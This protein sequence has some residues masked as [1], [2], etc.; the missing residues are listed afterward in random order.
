MLAKYHKHL[1]LICSF[2]KYGETST[3]SCRRTFL[4]CCAFCATNWCMREWQKISITSL[5]L[6]FDPC[7]Y[8]SSVSFLWRSSSVGVFIWLYCSLVSNRNVRNEFEEKKIFDLFPDL[9]ISLHRVAKD[10]SWTY[11]RCWEDITPQH[12]TKSI[13][14]RVSFL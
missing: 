13:C 11:W 7:T 3:K 9:F 14:V 5:F 4:V 10:L 8:F 2:Q 12:Y 1:F 6:L